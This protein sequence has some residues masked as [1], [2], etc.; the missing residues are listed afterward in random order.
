MQEVLSFVLVLA[1]SVCIACCIGGLYA[2]GLR[3]WTNGMTDTNSSNIWYR[4]GACVCF[5]LC[6][7][8]VLA[9]LWLII[10]FFH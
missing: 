8:I 10:P 6:V 7:I 2:S 9:A 5:A 4:I 1:A 3:L